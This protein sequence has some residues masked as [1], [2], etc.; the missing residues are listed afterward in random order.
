MVRAY[1][2]RFL[3][4]L[5][6]KAPDIEIN[7]EIIYK[8]QLLR[9]LI[10][11]VPAHLDWTALSEGPPRRSSIRYVRSITAY[12]FAGFLFRP[13]MFFILPGLFVLLLAAY[14]LNWSA[15]HV[16]EEFLILDGNLEFRI[17]QAFANAYTAFPHGFI[18]G[19]LALVMATQLISLGLASA[20][21]KRYFEELFHLGTTIHQRSLDATGPRVPFQQSSPTD[22]GAEREHPSQRV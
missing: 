9:G 17:S 18:V 12:G 10:V 16:V 11:E 8:A 21:A 15:I 5:D 1:D 3:Q 13:F 4:S 14:T 7:T 2:R 6:L 20:Q 22:S 19:G